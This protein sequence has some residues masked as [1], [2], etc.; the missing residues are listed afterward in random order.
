MKFISTE[1][2]LS[3]LITRRTYDI[4][5]LLFEHTKIFYFCIYTRFLVD[6]D[7]A[8]GYFLTLNSIRGIARLCA[9]SRRG[10]CV[11]LHS[12]NK[13]KK[14]NSAAAWHIQSY[15]PCVNDNDIK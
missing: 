7:P 5:E 14:K 12:N 9:I 6:D 10:W 8:G 3:Y 11:Q 4:L 13:D 1:E 2:V 15:K